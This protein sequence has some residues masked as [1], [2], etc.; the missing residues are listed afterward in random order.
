VRV[1]LVGL[2]RIEQVVGVLT[3]QLGVAAV[4]RLAEVGAVAGRAVALGQQLGHRAGGRRLRFGRQLGVRAALGLVVGG[5][6]E[7][8]LVAQRLGDAAHARVLALALLVGRERDA[9]YLAFWPA[10]FGTL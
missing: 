3:G 6:V 1:G 8:V 10:I 2:E 4:D 7:D 9:R 5:E